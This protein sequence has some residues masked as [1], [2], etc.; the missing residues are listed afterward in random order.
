MGNYAQVVLVD[1][2][3]RY[4]RLDES[5]GTTIYDMGSQRQNGTLHGGVTLS[6]TGLLTGDFNTCALFNGSSGYI[7]IPTTGLPSSGA[8]PWTLEGWVNVASSPSSFGAVLVL[9]N[10]PNN[11][12]LCY[13]GSGQ[14]A[15]L[16]DNTTTAIDPDSLTIHTTYHL[17]AVFDGSNLILYVN[18][19]DVASH[20]LSSVTLTYG[21]ASISDNSDYFNGNLDE[22]AIYT[23]ALSASQVQKHYLAGINLFSVNFPVV[24]ITTLVRDG[25]QA[26]KTRDGLSLTTQARG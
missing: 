18:G 26:T 5:T 22:V 6:Q 24:S 2:P 10:F 11:L 1:A 19:Q 23:T 20:S 15:I 7:S 8:S 9:G 13:K 12:E 14:F 21:N 17:V 3:I 4:Y 25:N 16:V